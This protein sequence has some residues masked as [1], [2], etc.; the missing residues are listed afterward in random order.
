MTEDPQPTFHRG[1]SCAKSRR[2]WLDRTSVQHDKN[3]V[4]D[5][6]NKFQHLDKAGNGGRNW[7]RRCGQGIRNKHARETRQAS[8][9]KH[10]ACLALPCHAM[11]LGRGKKIER[12]SQWGPTDWERSCSKK[13]GTSS[14]RLA[15][16]T[17]VVIQACPDVLFRRL[18]VYARPGTEASAS[19]SACLSL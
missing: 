6:F 19:D 2:C 5:G 9:E 3:G 15:S 7:R 1:W 18:V 10:E 12:S 16:V 8:H 4:E 17:P 13:K 11:P 14:S